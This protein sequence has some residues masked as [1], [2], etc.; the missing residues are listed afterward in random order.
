M[1]NFICKRCEGSFSLEVRPEL[2]ARIKPRYCFPCVE[3]EQKNYERV[4]ADETLKDMITESRIGQKHLE[5]AKKTKTTYSW[6]SSALSFVKHYKDG[7]DCKLPYFWGGVGTGKTHI[8]V[9]FAYKLMK[10]FSRA[11]LFS[12][13]TE[14]I[15]SSIDDKDLYHKFKQTYRTV[16]IDD[17]GNHSIT[18]WAIE[19]LYEVI[20]NRLN[21]SL[22]TM[23]TSNFNPIALEERLCSGAN[24][25][26]DKVVCRAITDR[27]LEICIPMKVD[28][29]SVRKIMFKESMKNE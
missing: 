1:K 19:K 25:S 11:V 27:L 18:Q 2:L 14:L 10:H 17:L 7:G 28:G 5:Y 12:T 23:F 6:Q 8:A 26:I 21:Y 4:K 13:A 20:N 9:L 24:V 3:I 22:P 15:R 29:E 16:I